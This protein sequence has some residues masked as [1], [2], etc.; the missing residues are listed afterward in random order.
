M[1]IT[2]FVEYCKEWNGNFRTLLET[3]HDCVLIEIIRLLFVSFARDI[4][5]LL[6]DKL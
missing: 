5:S 4:R 1:K 3:P 2:Q 6:T